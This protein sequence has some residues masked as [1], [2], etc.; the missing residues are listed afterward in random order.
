MTDAGPETGNG[1]LAGH[2]VFAKLSFAMR[3]DPGDVRPHNED[4]CAGYVPTIPDDA[5]EHGPIFVVADGLGGH[6]AGEVASRLA[7]ETVVAGWRRTKTPLPRPALRDVVRAA[8]TAVYDASLESGRRGMGTTVTAL[9]LNGHEAVVAHVGDSRAYLVR[10]GACRQLTSDHSRVGEMLRMKLLTPE[11]AANHPAR[12]QLTRS[13][14][15]DPTVQ[16]DVVTADVAE[17]DS[18]VLCS[19][20]LWDSV[21]RQELADIAGR[22]GGDTVATPV[23]AADMLV[24]LA[25]KRDA[26]D[27]VT[28]VVV[29]VTSSRPIPPTGTRRGFFRRR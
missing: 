29:H 5:W 17:G 11:Q 28:V 2:G 19:D 15:G 9:T 24:D 14:G 4:F 12:S 10:K 23:E 16:V 6:A 27:N 8:N 26:P 21:N 7:T 25:L 3:S 1:H 22:I 18:F 20:G 13:L